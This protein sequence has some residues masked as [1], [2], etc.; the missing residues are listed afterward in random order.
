MKRDPGRGGCLFRLP[1][2]GYHLSWWGSHSCSSWMQLII[3]HSHLT[4][5]RNACIQS[6]LGLSTLT[7]FCLPK[8]ARMQPP[9][10]DWISSH[11][12]RQ[13]DTSPV[14]LPQVNSLESLSLRLPPWLIS[15]EG[16]C[17]LKLPSTEGLKLVKVPVRPRRVSTED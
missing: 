8:P 11:V 14:D 9:T 7:Q 12:V 6:Q 1:I 17:Q 4:A 2:P 5:E 15:T 16:R 3:P 10:M 13:L